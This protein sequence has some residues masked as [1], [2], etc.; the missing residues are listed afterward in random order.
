MK[1]I[2]DAS[3]IDV[4]KER[5]RDDHVRAFFAWIAFMTLHP[6]DEPESG[7]MAFSLAAGRQRFSWI[8]PE[9]G[10]IR[11]PLALAR[12]IEEHGGTVLTSKRITRIAVEGGRATAVETEDGSTY[13]AARES[14]E[15]LKSFG[16]RTCRAIT[17]L[18]LRDGSRIS[19]CSSRTT[20]CR[21]RRAFG[22]PMASPPA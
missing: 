6:L 13:E 7:I 10:S 21:R 20:R 18:A 14:L 17:W 4:V 19:R 3:A 16:S 5:F 1:A 9:G 22:W 15:R 11:L 12:D 8:L 2:R